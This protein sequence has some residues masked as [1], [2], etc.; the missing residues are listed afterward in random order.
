MHFVFSQ[1]GTTLLMASGLPVLIAMKVN[2]NKGDHFVCVN[3]LEP[4]ARL[5]GR[6]VESGHPAHIVR[7]FACAFSRGN[8]RTRP[9]LFC[10]KLVSK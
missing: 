6:D 7:A 8:L 10:S 3:E 1:T 2:D 5:C 4:F 9:K